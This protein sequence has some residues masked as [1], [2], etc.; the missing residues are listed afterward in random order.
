MHLLELV[1]VDLL[2]LRHLLRHLLKIFPQ[3][4]IRIPEFHNKHIAQIAIGSVG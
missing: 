1:V 4:I 3:G 2:R